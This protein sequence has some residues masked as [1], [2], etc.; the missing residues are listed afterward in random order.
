[1]RSAQNYLFIAPMLD[2]S[3]TLANVIQST[4]GLFGLQPLLHLERAGA[5]EASFSE[6]TQR[7]LEQADLVIADISGGNP[8]VMYEIGL[9]QGLGK[10]ILPIVRRDEKEIPRSLGSVRYL[11]YDPEQPESL[12][13]YL[14]NWAAHYLPARV[15]S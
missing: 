10:A 5:G 8:N 14:K 2:T 13:R 3:T 6:T 9:A 7:S 4:L 11:V 15:E 1:M 12:S